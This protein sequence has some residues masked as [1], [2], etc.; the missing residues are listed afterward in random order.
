M[1]VELVSLFK[2]RLCQARMFQRD[3]HGHMERHG[4]Y[5]NGDW[6]DYFVRG[7]RDTPTRPGAHHKPLYHRKTA[8]RPSA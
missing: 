3:C 1:K 4:I 5:V 2:C 8:P 6:R 7:K